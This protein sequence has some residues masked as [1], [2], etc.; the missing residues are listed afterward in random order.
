MDGVND[1][2]DQL[3]ARQLHRALLVDGRHDVAAPDAECTEG[4]ARVDDDQAAGLELEVAAKA[5]SFAENACHY[6]LGNGRSGA[7]FVR[8]TPHGDVERLPRRLEALADGVV[9]RE[10]K[11]FLLERAVL[12]RDD[13]LDVF[14]AADSISVD[15]HELKIGRAAALARVHRPAFGEGDFN[16]QGRGNKPHSEKRNAG[17]EIRKNYS[18]T[19]LSSAG[20]GC[21]GRRVWASRHYCPWPGPPGKGNRLH[22]RRPDSSRAGQC[23][24]DVIDDC[25]LF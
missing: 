14:L 22:I 20:W 7:G 25:Q 4:G 11:R 5:F 13:V 15:V 18:G 8:R 12:A 10:P 23:E 6:L 1:V 16:V 3:R 19:S 24:C 2:G 9:Q 21:S 17:S